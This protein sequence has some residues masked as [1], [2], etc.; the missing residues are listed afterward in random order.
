MGSSQQLIFGA[1][2]KTRRLKSA[3]KNVIA[4]LIVLPKR[5]RASKKSG[6]LFSLYAN[7]TEGCQEDNNEVLSQQF[8]ARSSEKGAS[9][10]MPCVAHVQAMYTVACRL[11]IWFFIGHFMTVLFYI[12]EFF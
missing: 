1:G 9:L 12:S 11:L 4:S 10:V 6:K 8:T 2:R 3:E 5:K 7:S